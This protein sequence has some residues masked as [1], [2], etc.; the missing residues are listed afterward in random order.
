MKLVAHLGNVEVTKEGDKS[1][2]Q[3]TSASLWYALMRVYT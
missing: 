1:P 3:L 2:E